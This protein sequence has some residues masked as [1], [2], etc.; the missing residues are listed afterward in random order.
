MS[1]KKLIIGMHPVVR[2]CESSVC[3]SVMT[4]TSAKKSN[5][6]LELAVESRVRPKLFKERVTLAEHPEAGTLPVFVWRAE[7]PNRRLQ[8]KTSVGGQ[9]SRR[10]CGACPQ[11]L[12]LK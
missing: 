12:V 7:Y 5:V 11:T 4:P 3:V 8:S 6:A 1:E 9:I 10:I 2:K